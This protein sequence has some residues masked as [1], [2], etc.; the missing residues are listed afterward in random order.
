MNKYGFHQ[1]DKQAKGAS[2]EITEYLE[3]RGF[4]VKNVEDSWIYQKMDIDLLAFKDGRIYW[5]EI[6]ADSYYKTGNYFAES[7]SNSN[8]NSLGCW[9]KTK[10]HFIFY[11]FTKEKELHIINTIQAQNWTTS[12]KKSLKTRK[13]S[14]KGYNGKILY[15]SEGYLINRKLL[16]NSIDIDVKYL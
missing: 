11:Y 9:F 14:T 1:Q 2:Q 12:H 15:E 10:S 5:I 6:K 16:Q 7:I 13:T 4:V 3:A 8:T